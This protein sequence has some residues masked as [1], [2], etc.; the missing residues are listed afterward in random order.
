MQKAITS[1]CALTL[2]LVTPIYSMQR[3]HPYTS[4]A[5]RTAYHTTKPYDIEREFSILLDESLHVKTE[6]AKLK[7]QRSFWKWATAVLGT[8]LAT[9]LY[10]L[11]EK[12]LENDVCKEIIAH[13]AQRG[14]FAH[15]VGTKLFHEL[16][17]SFDALEIALKENKD[18][19]K[20]L[21][22]VHVNNSSD[23][24]LLYMSDL[25]EYNRIPN[26]SALSSH[27]DKHQQ[28]IAEAKVLL[29]AITQAFSPHTYREQA[30]SKEAQEVILKGLL[31]ETTWKNFVRAAAYE[32]TG[33]ENIKNA[34]WLSVFV[35]HAENSAPLNDKKE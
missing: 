2:A 30:S 27:L 12:K 29:Q 9:T 34:Y 18:V 6:A 24:D 10:Y 1:I 32:H 31:N 17:G 14:I 16:Y 28:K 19:Q 21:N 22:P 33:M 8:G 25:T 26:K 20:Y 7:K 15:M 23:D 5:I 3:L 35:Q 11:Y 4:K 13:E